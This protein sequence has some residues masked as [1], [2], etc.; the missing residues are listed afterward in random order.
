MGMT[1][2][3]LDSRPLWLLLAIP[4]SAC[5]T[6]LSRL[7]K[8]IVKK[9]PLVRNWQCVQRDL[10]SWLHLPCWHGASLG[11]PCCLLLCFVVT[12]SPSWPCAGFVLG[13]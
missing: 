5:P 11:L 8:D 9:H 2:W 10:V 13:T 3:E 6:C 12:S 1:S 4:D 7:H